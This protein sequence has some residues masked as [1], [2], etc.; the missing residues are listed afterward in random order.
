MGFDDMFLLLKWN[1]WNV[2]GGCGGL[3]GTLQFN[4]FINRK[5]PYRA[6]SKKA[7][8][9]NSRITPSPNNQLSNILH[10]VSRLND[11]RHT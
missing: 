4:D 7:N 6:A 2:V 8:A 3:H 1:F 11:N 10:Q 5:S 9:T